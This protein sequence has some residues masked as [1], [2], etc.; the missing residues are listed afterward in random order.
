MRRRRSTHRTVSAALSLVLATTLTAGCS[1]F[2]SEPDPAEAA[3][4]LAAGLA[5]A[6][7][8]GLA[9]AGS[10][11]EQATQFIAKAYEDMGDLRPAV[12][13][14]SVATDEEKRRAGLLAVEAYPAG[15]VR[16]QLEVR[17]RL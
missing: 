3:R 2:G 14:K 5:K 10:T 16:N 13:V 12:T 7:L 8:S 4:S 17:Q 6:N 9:L 1:L 15:Q 11:P